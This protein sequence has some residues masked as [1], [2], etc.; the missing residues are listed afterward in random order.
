MAWT[1]CNVRLSVRP[2]ALL[3]N[4]VDRFVS[5][6]TKSWTVLDKSCTMVILPQNDMKRNIWGG[7]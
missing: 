3:K 4:P 6:F 7:G 1:A 5:N 2:S